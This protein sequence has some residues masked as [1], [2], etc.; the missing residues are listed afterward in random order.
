MWYPDGVKTDSSRPNERHLGCLIRASL[1]IILLRDN[2]HE[3]ADHALHEAVT[4]FISR[5]M[6][7]SVAQDVLLTHAAFTHEIYKSGK[8]KSILLLNGRKVA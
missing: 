2:I 3:A 8:L 6:Q 7:W 4:A 1:S 5:L